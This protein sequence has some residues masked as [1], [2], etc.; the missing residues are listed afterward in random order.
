MARLLAP[1]PPL[2]STT[3][4][5]TLYILWKIIPSESFTKPNLVMQNGKLILLFCQIPATSPAA[6]AIEVPPGA[7]AEAAAAAASSDRG[8]G[9]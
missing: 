9:R 3:T 7:G 1:L 4:W 5:A 6:A 2:S 8:R